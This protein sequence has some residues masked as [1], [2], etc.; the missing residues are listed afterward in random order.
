MKALVLESRGAL[1][2]R[3]LE[4][5][6]PGEGML[7][8]R[9]AYAGICATDLHAYKGEY[10]RTKFPVVLG[11]EL[12]G[13]VHEVGPGV[14][15]FAPG[16]RVTCETTFAT[17]GCCESC[18]TMDYN[19]CANRSGIG[20]DKNGAFAEYILVPAARV[21]RL[22]EG[23]SLLTGSLC[24]PLSCAVH[25]CIEKAEVRPG[26]KVCVFGVGAIGML[27]AQVAK[28]Q[29]A[30]VV[31]AGLSA[32]RARLDKAQAEMGVD[33]VVD[34]QTQDL[35]AVVMELTGGEGVDACF[36]CSGALPALNRSFELVKKKGCVIQMGVFAKKTNEIPTDMLLHKE[37]RYIG[38]RS[39]KPS[40]WVKSLE[41]LSRGTVEPQLVVGGVFPLEDWDAA[42]QETLTNPGNRN[43]ICCSPELAGR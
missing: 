18:R 4:Y 34:Q 11:H 13:L 43:I 29:G 40:S 19:L 7:T 24:E 15:S 42:F 1:A 23:V 10:S 35:S 14:D 2:L 26:E 36:E 8:I 37:I 41:L 30:F 39:Q 27:V 33:I 6:K 5:P 25:A 17:C 20:T 38:S 9:V 21:H 16:D 3:D 12:A 32:D 28:S 22:P 31:L